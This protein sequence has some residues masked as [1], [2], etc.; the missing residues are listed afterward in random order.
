MFDFGHFMKTI[1]AIGTVEK[2]RN[3]KQISEIQILVV[4]TT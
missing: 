1:W 3:I 2:G 4:H